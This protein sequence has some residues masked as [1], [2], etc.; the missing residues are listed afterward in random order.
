MVV[1]IIKQPTGIVD[2]ESIDN[3]H[4]GR[5]YDVQAPLA[6]YLVLEGYAAI[7]MRRQKRSERKRLAERRRRR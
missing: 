1:K 4:V 7:E 3:F 2:G 5:C 6:A